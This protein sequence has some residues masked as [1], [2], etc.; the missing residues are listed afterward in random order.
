[1]RNLLL[2][3]ASKLLATT[4]TPIL[5]HLDRS[6]IKPPFISTIPS[7][8]RRDPEDVSFAMPIRGV[9]SKLLVLTQIAIST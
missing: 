5:C 1:V 4:R 2:V 7:A 3:F 9:F 8:E 6:A